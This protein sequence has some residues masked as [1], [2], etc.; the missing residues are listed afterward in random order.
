M[1]RVMNFSAGPAALPEEAL[2][3]ARDELL[4]WNGTGM[5]VMEQSHR[6]KAYEKVHQEAHDL[7]R[8]LLGLTADDKRSVIFLQGG[9][10]Q[11]FAT[12]A[13]NFLRAGT[14]ADY[15]S[16]GAWGD[17]ALVEAK[18]YAAMV[19]ASAREVPW[20]GAG[21]GTRMPHPRELVFAEDA[22][23]VHT[24][25]NETIH[26]TQVGLSE[27][28]PFAAPK[29]PHVCDMSSDFLGRVIDPRKFSLL[30]AG[31]QK[32][33]GPSGVVVLV[34][35]DAFLEASRDDIP[36]IF[37]YATHAKNGSL[38]NTPPTFAIYLVRNVLAWLDAKG[39]VP[40]IEKDNRAKAKLVYDAIDESGGFYTCPVE[41]ES[42]SIMN[43]VFR[44]PSEAHEA[45]FLAASEQAGMVGLK[46]HRSV[47]GMR[48]SLYNAVTIA[49]AKALA[50][51]MRE[52]ARTSG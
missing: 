50:D 39:G 33:I 27:S 1:T 2:L 8:K 5:S 49:H 16:A 10:T 3:R 12:L 36:S 20:E 29:Q 40:A 48:A 31:A 47:G 42:R 18:S 30:Y 52:H 24:T 7:L 45:K 23:F 14:S 46:G 4:D 19:G 26:G 28:L 32:N 15:V 6:G 43:V 13:M 41:A 37:R 34:V 11:V 21:K 35:D 51:L 22:V 17:K 38:Y 25:S 9:A 44:L